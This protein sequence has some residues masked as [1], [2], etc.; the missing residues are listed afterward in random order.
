MFFFFFYSCGEWI[1]ELVVARSKRL[2]VVMLT[3]FSPSGVEFIF[4]F[5]V[6]FRLV[7]GLSAVL[8]SA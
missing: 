6:R 8:K 2:Y 7:T 1:E 5:F 3:S 4:F